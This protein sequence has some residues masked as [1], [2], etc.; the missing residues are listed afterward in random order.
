MNIILLHQH[1]L[2][3]PIPLGDRRAVH[4]REHLRGEVG[5][6]FRA[7]IIGGRTG[8]LEII[9]IDDAGLQTRFTPAADP[10][11]AALPISLLIGHPRPPAAERLVRD[12]TAL[13]VRGV[14]FFC[15][16]NSQ[17]SY[18]DSRMW[19]PER[20][21]DLICLGLEQSGSTAVPTVTCHK[22]LSAAL[23]AVLKPTPP[24]GQYRYVL[25]C[26]NDEYTAPQTGTP[27]GAAQDTITAIGPERGWEPGELS[28]LSEHGFER[29]QCGTRVLR[30]ETVAVAW[31]G[32]LVAG[33][34]RA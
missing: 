19:D 28:L 34:P 6:T 11:A 3:T 9:A 22:D 31:C 18:A 20:L 23:R 24:A 26:T 30:T 16:E 1:E 13:G 10:A 17:R 32:V 14:H 33:M 12:L 8:T 2:H 21:Q 25:C 7:G 27:S 29:A 15:G 5:S 4:I